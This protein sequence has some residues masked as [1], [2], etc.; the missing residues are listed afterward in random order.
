MNMKWSWLL[1]A[2]GLASIVTVSARSCTMLTKQPSERQSEQATPQPSPDSSPSSNSSVETLIQAGDRFHKERKLVEAHDAYQ[3]ATQIN[4]KNAEA[5]AKLGFILIVSAKPTQAIAAYQ[6]AIALNPKDIES[7]NMLSSLLRMG[8][9]RVEA[10]AVL[11]KA[12]QTSPNS[13]ESY[14]LLGLNLAYED[15]LAEASEACNRAIQ[16]KPD[17]AQAYSCRGI[18]LT[19]QGKLD[20]AISAYQKSIKLLSAESSN[21]N[22]D[23]GLQ[24]LPLSIHYYHLSLAFTAQGKRSEAVDTYNLALKISEP[25]LSPIVNSSPTSPRASVEIFYRQVPLSA[26]YFATPHKQLGIALKDKG[27]LEEA[28]FVFQLAKELF[29]KQNNQEQVAAIDDLLKGIKR[30]Q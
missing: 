5:F 30:T 9:K 1:I 29:A 7:H 12:V 11:R 21:S 26:K 4:P 14:R 15:N 27:Q 16:L 22:L 19:S 25:L 13:A 24:K 2:V 10:I 18:I 17:Y 3:K 28:I 8:G 20:E 23:P 6:K